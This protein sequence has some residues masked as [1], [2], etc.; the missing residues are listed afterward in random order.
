MISW[1]VATHRPEVLDAVLRPSLEPLP[2]GDEVVVVAGAPSIAAAY[3]E[4]GRRAGNRVQVYVHHDVR[5]LDLAGLRDEVLAACGDGT[6]GLAGVIGSTVPVVPWWQ[7]TVCGS[8]Q[9]ARVRSLHAGPGGHACA[10]LDGLLL[11]TARDVRWDESIPG[12]HLYDHDMCQQML[13]AGLRNWCL[14]YG[15]RLVRH[16][17]GGPTDMGAVTGWEQARVR[18]VAKWSTTE[19]LA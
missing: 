2:A 1:V 19:V 11:A 6:V 3:N 5:V 13:A 15:D 18:F 8:V 9:D 16:E 7:G 17:T 10:Y 14:P 4:G 12:W